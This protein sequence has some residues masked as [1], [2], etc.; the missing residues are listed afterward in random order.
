MR[1]SNASDYFEFDIEASSTESSFHRPSNADAVQQDEDD[2][3]WES[4]ARLPPVKQTRT[5]DRARKEL[6]VKKALAADDQGNYKLLSAVKDR[7]HRVGLEVPKVEVRF[8]NLNID[9]N[10]QIGSRA[11][12]STLLNVA[13]G[14]CENV[15]IGL[16]ILRPNKFRL[17]ILK[18]ISGVVK[19]G[20][21][22]C[23]PGDLRRGLLCMGHAQPNH[24]SPCTPS[25]LLG[26]HARPATKE[27]AMH[28][29]RPRI[30]AWGDRAMHSGL[31][32]CMGHSRRPRNG[33]C[34]GHSGPWSPGKVASR[35][36]CSRA[37]MGVHGRAPLARW[38]CMGMEV[39]GWMTLLLGPPGSSKSTLLLA[40]AGKLDHKSLKKASAYI[41]QSDN[42]IPELTVQETLDFAARC[43]GASEGMA[44]PEVDAFM[45]ASSVGG[46]KHGISTD[47]VLKVLGLDECSDTVVGNEMLRGVSGGQRKRVTRAIYSNAFIFLKSFER[48]PREEVLEFFESLGFKL[49]PRKGVADFP[50]E[51][52]FVTSTL[53]LRTRLHPRH[54]TNGNLYISALFFGV[55]HL[56]FNGFSE[57]PLLTFRLP[58]FYK[59]RDNLFHP[60]WLWS[61]VSWILRIP[62]SAVEAI[63]WSCVVYYTIGFA[64]S[65]GRFLRF[66]FLKFVVHQM[67][68]GLFRTLAAVARDIVAGNQT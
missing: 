64:P 7:L 45:K 9:A 49:P 59:Q 35:R 34:M 5:L 14:F 40:L 25:D 8:Q 56:M 21:S 38:A 52:A 37:W 4:I 68:N 42:H 31:G 58:V 63:V 23:L 24:R 27:V 19:P 10:A 3:I 66:M 11:L 50:Q 41:S 6:V 39:V 16:R 2:L 54:E 53:F 61:I 43:Q 67:V 51:V 12:P 28:S 26:R 48:C 65:V 62:Y 47:Y 30:H 33:S 57:L 46:K 13:R 36:A 60:A 1:K 15:L 17:L 55:V 20:R 32:S 44:V 29:G 22:P 18:D